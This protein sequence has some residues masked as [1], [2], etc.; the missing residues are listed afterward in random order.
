MYNLILVK[1]IQKFVLQGWLFP[2]NSSGCSD[3]SLSGKEAEES[4]VQACPTRGLAECSGV[5]PAGFQALCL[6][7]L[8]QASADQTKKGLVIGEQPSEMKITVA[9]EHQLPAKAGKPGELGGRLAAWRN[10]RSLS[11]AL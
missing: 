8:H 10:S 1:T 7:S 3:W 4:L 2:G 9:A 6:E 11:E 5:I